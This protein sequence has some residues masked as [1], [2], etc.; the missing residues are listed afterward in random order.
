MRFP[1]GDRPWILDFYRDAVERA[2]WRLPDVD[3]LN[4]LFETAECARIANR[5]IWPASALVSD[6]AEWGFDSLA[7]IARWFD[8]L[9]PV[10]V[11]PAG[12]RAGAL[13]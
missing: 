7:E 10:I 1:E 12:E 11:E 3:D 5:V 2:G 4:L 9:R 8:E 6:R 13:V